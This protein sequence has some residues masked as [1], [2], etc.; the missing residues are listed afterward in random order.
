MPANILIFIEFEVFEVFEMSGH[1]GSLKDRDRK[2]MINRLNPQHAHIH[3]MLTGR[4][5][6]S[7]GDAGNVAT[8]LYL[9]FNAGQMSGKRLRSKIADKVGT[10]TCYADDAYFIF[11]ILIIGGTTSVMML[12]AMADILRMD[13]LAIRGTEEGNHEHPAAMVIDMHI[14]ADYGDKVPETQ[15]KAGDG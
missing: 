13:A 8:S 1:S 9:R 10:V 11:T 5:R 6:Q 4:T 2:R 14:D 7:G 15:Q 3:Q 12:D